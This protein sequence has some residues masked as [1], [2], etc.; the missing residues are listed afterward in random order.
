MAVISAA[1]LRAARGLLGW[2]QGDLAEAAKVGRATITDFEAGKREPYA[3]TLDD[4]R[5]ALEWAGVE[6]TNSDKPGVRLMLV[7]LRSRNYELR[8]RV[9]AACEM[10]P[11]ARPEIERIA[12]QLVVT[13]LEE[14]EALVEGYQNLRKRQRSLE[15]AGVEFI[16]E[17]PGV[18]L[19]KTAER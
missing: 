16:D 6:F 3:R 8:R 11:A 2:S 12:S 17:P 18:R 13:D 5:A 14:A 1:Q 9:E 15:A 10:L 4:L 7:N 19:R